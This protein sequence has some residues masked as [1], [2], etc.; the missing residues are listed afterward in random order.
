MPKVTGLLLNDATSASVSVF[1]LKRPQRCL[2][3]SKN[4]EIMKCVLSIKFAVGQRTLMYLAGEIRSLQ[5][6]M[7]KHDLTRECFFFPRG[8]INQCVQFVSHGP[9]NKCGSS[10]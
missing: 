8:I 5:T 2:A 3:H 10:M 4:Y 9:I 6:Q 7:E 1:V